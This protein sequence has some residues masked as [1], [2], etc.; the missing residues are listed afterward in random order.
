MTNKR[1]VAID[2]THEPATPDYNGF[3]SASDKGLIDALRA[4][5]PA[6]DATISTTKEPTGFTNNQNITVSYDGT[7]R[8]VT[9]TGTFEA[10]YKGVLVRELIDGW[11]SE[12]HDVAQGVYYLYYCDDGFVFNTTPWDFSCLMICFVQYN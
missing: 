7:T 6:Y 8:K 9:L 2:H 10:Y 5:K 11:V 3:F 4:Q 1:P 12:A